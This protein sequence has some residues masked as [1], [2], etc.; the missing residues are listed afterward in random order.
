MQLL[1]E[2]D[3]LKSEEKHHVIPERGAKF[4][5]EVDLQHRITYRSPQSDKF[6][7]NGDDEIKGKIFSNYVILSDMPKADHAFQMVISEKRHEVLRI[8]IKCKDGKIIRLETILTP[9]FSN[10]DVMGVRGIA[11]MITA[12]A[13]ECENHTIK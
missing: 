5:F 13:K 6:L 8:K 10:R 1:A 9:I 12:S 11:R 4:L 7:G 2:A 3:S